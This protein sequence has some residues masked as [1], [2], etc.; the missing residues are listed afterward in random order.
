MAHYMVDRFANENDAMR[1][2]TFSVAA[3]SDTEAIREAQTH[4]SYQKQ[5]YFRVRVVTRK[6]DR[7]IYDSRGG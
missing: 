7:I 3:G 2:D 1:T 5:A 6:G 4:C